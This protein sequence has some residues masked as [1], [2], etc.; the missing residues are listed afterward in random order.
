MFKL[1]LWLKERNEHIIETKY[2]GRFK[3]FDKRYT[4]MYSL[5]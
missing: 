4:K 3:A 2:N 1:V 5:F